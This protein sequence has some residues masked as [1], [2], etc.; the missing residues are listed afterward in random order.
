MPTT[1]HYEIFGA[2]WIVL[3]IEQLYKGIQKKSVL[4]RLYLPLPMDGVRLP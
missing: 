3:A 4:P 2:V 1:W